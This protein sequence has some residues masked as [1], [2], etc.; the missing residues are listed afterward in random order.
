VTVSKGV[1]RFLGQISPL[2]VEVTEMPESTHTAVEAAQAVGVGVEAIVK[3]LVFLADG[4]PLLVLASGPNRVNVEAL[5]Q[6]LGLTLEKADAD[7]V[8]AHTGYSIGGVPPFG[9]LSPIPTVMDEDF[10]ALEVVW[11]AAGSA[12]AVFPLTPEK[13]LEYSQA[14]VVRVD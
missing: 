7:T 12:K 2:T 5:G 3:S 14:K 8:K 1:V 6:R 13:L 4:N 10:M 11:A 9:H